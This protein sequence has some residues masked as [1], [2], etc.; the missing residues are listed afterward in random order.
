MASKW[1]ASLARLPARTSL[2]SNTQLQGDD[3]RT[4][5]PGRGST[6]HPTPQ[7]GLPLSRQRP[8]KEDEGFISLLSS[9]DEDED[10]RPLSAR[11]P[12]L[13]AAAAAR[14]AASA[15]APS[16]V[17]PV[18]LHRGRR[19]ELKS[20]ATARSLGDI[21]ADYDDGNE[22][23]DDFDLLSSEDDDDDMDEDLD[24]DG[25]DGDEECEEED[26]GSESDKRNDGDS[27]GLEEDDDD[28]EEEGEGG[29]QIGPD[30]QWGSTGRRSTSRRRT[31]S[32]SHR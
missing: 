6:L 21:V 11:L 22:E 30:L 18:V 12:L 8:S 23:N 7:P 31:C 1:E 9:E 15:C 14:G 17:Q 32:V 27:E 28:D 29:L 19:A 16:G 20:L 2:G 10:E 4:N 5:L 24:S 25:D 3:S 13:A 26:V